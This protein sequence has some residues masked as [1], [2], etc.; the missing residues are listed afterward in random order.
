M[1]ICSFRVWKMKVNSCS[2]PIKPLVLTDYSNSRTICFLFIFSIW[3]WKMSSWGIISVRCHW[4]IVKST[5]LRRAHTPKHMRCYVTACYWLLPWVCAR[6]LMCVCV[7]RLE[8]SHWI[9]KYCSGLCR[10]RV[11]HRKIELLWNVEWNDRIGIVKGGILSQAREELVFSFKCHSTANW[12]QS[13]LITAYQFTC[14][15]YHHYLFWIKVNFEHRLN[16]IAVS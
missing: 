5:H 6:M 8:L 13:V 15:A 4:R 3:N 7:I 16:I 12:I 10:F 9:M 11:L 2:I 14:S 1:K